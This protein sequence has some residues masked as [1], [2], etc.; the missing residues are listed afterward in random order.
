MP[1]VTQLVS[2]RVSYLNSSL[3]TFKPTVISAKE[4]KGFGEKK[5]WILESISLVKNDNNSYRRVGLLQGCVE[6]ESESCLVVSD[7]L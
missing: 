7:F 4:S 6:S 5:G 1:E 3:F 2:I